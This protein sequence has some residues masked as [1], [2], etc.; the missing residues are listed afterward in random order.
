TSVDRQKVVDKN[1][2]F[3]IRIPK[4][5][6]LRSQENH[7]QVAMPNLQENHVNSNSNMNT[8]SIQMENRTNGGF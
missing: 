3:E 5:S 7:V 8:E 4:C 1:L 2:L 6:I